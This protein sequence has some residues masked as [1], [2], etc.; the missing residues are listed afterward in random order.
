[1]FFLVIVEGLLAE[2]GVKVV[3][4]LL[5]CVLVRLILVVKILVIFHEF[6]GL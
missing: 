3:L 2:R 4:Y 1:M 6:F 5:L